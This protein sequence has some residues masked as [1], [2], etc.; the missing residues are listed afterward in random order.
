M[1][2]ALLAA[3]AHPDDETFAAAG[4]LSRYHQQRVR[5][6]LFTATDGEAGRSGPIEVCDRAQLARVRRAELLRGAAIIGIDRVFAA[7]FPDG[8][9]ERHPADE[10]LAALVA[11][12]REVRPG[13]ILTFGPEGGP[14][15]HPDHKVISRLATAAFFL[16]GNPTIF[17]QGGLIR[18]GERAWSPSRLFYITWP[19]PPADAAE[20]LIGTPTTCRIAVTPHLDTKRRAFAEYKSQQEHRTTFESTLCPSEDYHLASGIP[21]ISSPMDDLFAGL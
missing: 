13:V 8:E 5:T 12:I 2:G 19:N 4:T 11:T 14:N 3:F 18:G 1:P 16:A 7:G 6:A 15:Q 10:V 21:P 20:P 17:T 9:L